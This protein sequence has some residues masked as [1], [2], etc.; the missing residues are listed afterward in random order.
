MCKIMYEFKL[1]FCLFV[2]LFCFFETGSLCS[3]GC[4]G[5]HSVAYTGLELRDLPAFAGI[6]GI[7]GVCY[8]YQNGLATFKVS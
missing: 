3:L 2:C 5:T 6:K 1:E 4:P 8:Y 7:K